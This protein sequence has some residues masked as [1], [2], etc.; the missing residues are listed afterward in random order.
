M[1]YILGLSF[2]FNASA[3]IMDEDH[4]ILYAASEERFTNIKNCKQ[5]PLL[6]IRNGLLTTGIPTNLV[7]VCRY[8]HYQD[9]DIYDL[10]RHTYHID[11]KLPERD[12]PYSVG[13]CENCWKNRDFEEQF[14]RHQLYM[15]G[16]DVE[17][18]ERIE[19]HVAHAMCSF[20]LSPF[21]KGENNLYIVMDGFG[22]GKSISFWV[23]RDRTLK[24]IES[25]PMGKSIAL[26]YQFVT[27]ALGYKEH[28]HEGKLTGLAAYG[29][30]E[31]YYAEFIKLY[32][33]FEDI[34]NKPVQSPIIDFHIFKE[35]K[36]RTYEFV[37]SITEGMLKDE[38]FEESKHI[39]ASLQ[40]FAED[41]A[42]FYVEKVIH[43]NKLKDL[44]V[45]LS[46]GLFA[47]VK[48][49]QRIHEGISEVK[50]VF[51][52]P[53][54]GDE[55][56]C[57]GAACGNELFDKKNY[58][59]TNMTMRMGTRTV[60]EEV[61]CY[62]PENCEIEEFIGV[63]N[64]SKAVAEDL[65]QNKIVCLFDGKMEFGPRALIGRSIMY[66]CRDVGAN[67]WLNKQLG[68][69]EFMPFAPFCKEEHASDLFYSVKGKEFALKNMTVTVNCKKEFIQNYPAACHVDNTARPQVIS[70]SEN[71]IAWSILNEYEKLTGEKVLINTSFNL[72]NYPII[73]SP[74]VAVESWMK[75]NT[76]SLYIGSC[77]QWL[78]ITR[79]N[80]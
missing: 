5:F 52:A 24:L 65:G 25:M 15:L 22:D 7:K 78:K 60:I 56:T 33:G 72:H 53:P 18:V 46:G 23:E 73:E 79:K 28:Q 75:S 61:K 44:N 13:S 77:G 43:R 10:Y 8:S 63:E 59:M 21:K 80:S 62:V 71:N 67:D 31:K 30:P 54:M 9:A 39:A 70:Q 48:I 74:K 49:N 1:K 50:N 3:C 27:G 14:I 17:R 6:A 34:C 26:V 45:M 19:H 29:N 35:M 68:R 55:G 38:K 36:K 2:G 57:I 66:N 37:N 58:T 20:A 12:Y 16:I 76:Q 11:E 41:M 32:N 4:N 47:N 42:L 40:K 64:L 51:I 69:T